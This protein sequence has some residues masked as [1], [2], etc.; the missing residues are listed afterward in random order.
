M[1]ERVLGLIQ[2]WGDAFKG[3]P[4]LSAVEEL[5][6]RMKTDGVEFPPIDLDALAPI[7]TPSGRVSQSVNACLF[8]IINLHFVTLNR[9]H[10]SNH[11]VR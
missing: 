7:E 4:Q 5:Y 1:K 8:L 11:V 9:A 2:Y 6:E 10:H 3:R